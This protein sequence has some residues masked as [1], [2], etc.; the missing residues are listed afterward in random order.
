ME[1][2]DQMAYEFMYNIVMDLIN[3]RYETGEYVGP[4]DTVCAVFTRSGKIYTGMSHM[5]DIG[6]QSVPV[7][8]E[9]DAVRNMQ[10]YNETAIEAMILALAGSRG[11]IVPC[12]NCLGVIQA[13]DSQNS[14]SWIIVSDRLIRMDEITNFVSPQPV[15]NIGAM[16]GEPGIPPIPGP[17]TNALIPDPAALRN[18]GSLIP[19]LDGDM[20]YSTERTYST[21]TEKA[22]GE[23]L[24]K[25]LNSL[26][27]VTEDDDEDE[28][29]ED[30][31]K[32]RR[33]FGGL[34]GR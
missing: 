17:V 8:A 14:Q 29:P 16:A 1:R 4:D 21:P 20:P 5:E 7:H 11:L 31:K 27:S 33:L 18:K 22:N 30:N 19:D 2:S 10:A 12:N 15:A 3:K 24:K 34:F 28:K 13:L 26:M 9:I 6:G 32:G 23:Y 25:R